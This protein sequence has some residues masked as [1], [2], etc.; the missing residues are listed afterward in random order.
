MQHRKFIF[1]VSGEI[2]S[3][4]LVSMKSI[5]ISCKLITE[6]V[7]H[8]ENS[9]HFPHSTSNE[10]L[11]KK[12]DLSTLLTKLMQGAKT[13]A[14]KFGNSPISLLES[15]ITDVSNALVSLIEFMN[16]VDPNTEIN[17][18]ELEK[19]T[20]NASFKFDKMSQ[21]NNR[22]TQKD[23]EMIQVPTN[24]FENNN[25]QD[26]EIPDNIQQVPM[27]STK[28]SDNMNRHDHEFSNKVTAHQVPIQAQRNLDI[29]QRE[30]YEVMKS[31][32][33]IKSNQ[34]NDEQQEQKRVQTTVEK[35][36]QSRDSFNI[37]QLKVF[38]LI[39]GLS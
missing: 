12:T 33:N 23:K 27:H 19:E 6:Q 34:K 37:G 17:D 31:H 7:E 26:R 32:E 3:N 21:E 18:D 11:S 8:Y 10:I 24:S 25:R 15:C 4:V 30:E 1:I 16:R 29:N 28:S 13:H 35:P 14:T 39:V 5:V 20:N 2:P 22:T 36:V 38:L 9:V